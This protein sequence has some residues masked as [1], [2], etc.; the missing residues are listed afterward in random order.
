MII[1]TGFSIEIKQNHVSI[2]CINEYNNNKS[3]KII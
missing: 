1:K 3:E 2:I